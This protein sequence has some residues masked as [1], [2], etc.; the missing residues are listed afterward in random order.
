MGSRF[1]L[2]L[3]HASTHTIQNI[4]ADRAAEQERLLLHNTDLLAQILARIIAQF[5]AIEQDLST[6]VIV[7]ARQQVDQRGLTRT[8]RAKQRN[9]L[10]RP[11][12]ERNILDDIMR[13]IGIHE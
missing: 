1:D 10:S 3:S 4:L 12:V 8:G 5:H 7:E 2:F 9:G 6:S 13:P 11:D